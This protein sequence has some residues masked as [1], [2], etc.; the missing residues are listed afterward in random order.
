MRC[1]HCRKANQIKSA[2][3][4]REFAAKVAR[5]KRPRGKQAELDR[6]T[7][8]FNIRTVADEIGRSVLRERLLATTT[9]LFGGLALVLAAIGLYGVL[10]YGVTRRTRELGIRIAIGAT[11]QRI[12][13]LVLQEA[14][15][16]VGVGIAAG[17]GAAWA[18]GRIV[19]SLLFGIGPMDLLSVAV[20]VAVL[21]AAGTLAASIPA[22]RASKVD[23][24]LALRYE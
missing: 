20:A 12:L 18:L 10:S 6:D 4:P 15:W 24:V 9:A 7:P 23:P 8:V 14:G 17:L 11:T 21:A 2:R 1:G 16:V 22:R 3:G 19:S 13:W 5:L